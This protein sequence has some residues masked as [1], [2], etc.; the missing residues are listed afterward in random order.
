MDDQTARARLEQLLKDLDQSQQTLE[1]ENDGES[2]ELSHVDQ[3]PADV[4]SDVSEN[5]RDEAMVEV[6]RAQR[7]AVQEALARLDAGTYGRCVV[8]GEPI[9]DERLEA[10]PEAARCLKH[11]AEQ[12]AA[13]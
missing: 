1:D 11:Q 8:D 9:G 4:A 6:V 7:V 2:V 5:D 10:R 3:H 13:S 12:E